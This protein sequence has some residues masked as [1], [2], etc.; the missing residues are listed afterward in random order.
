L[1]SAETGTKASVTLRLVDQE[2]EVIWAYTQDSAGGKNKGAVAD[3]VERAM[4][5]LQRDA[6]R[7]ED[8]PVVGAPENENGL[9]AGRN[10]LR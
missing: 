1:F 5:Q 3:A 4:K 6:S 7:S 2:G 8:K 9:A 10:R